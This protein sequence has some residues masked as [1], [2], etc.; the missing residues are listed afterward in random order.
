MSDSHKPFQFTFANFNIDE[1]LGF[2]FDAARK[3]LFR[4]LD[5]TNFTLQSNR[6]DSSKGVSHTW[7]KIPWLKNHTCMVA[8]ER[9]DKRTIFKGVEDTL[10]MVLSHEK[11]PWSYR[12]E[13]QTRQ[14]KKDSYRTDKYAVKALF[15]EVLPTAIRSG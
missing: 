15:N 1:D 9:A 11:T 3:G 5:L 14:N 6:K 2:K 7:M 12:A 10:S 4:P 8:V 13:Y